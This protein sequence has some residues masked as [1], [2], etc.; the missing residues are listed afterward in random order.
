M[1]KDNVYKNGQKISELNNGILTHYYK[2]GNK[3]AEGK[4]IDE[5]FEGKWLF[6]S[7]AGAVIQE[8]NFAANQKHGDWTRYN[9]KGEITYHEVF[10]Y[11]K[12]LKGNTKQPTEKSPKELF[13]SFCNKS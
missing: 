2:S 4:F 1:D 10:Q 5:K 13:C 6:Y 8:G 11:G 12:K 9:E 7:E 3:K